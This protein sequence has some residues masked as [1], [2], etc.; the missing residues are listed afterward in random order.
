MIPIKDLITAPEEILDFIKDY[1]GKI[2]SFQFMI[3]A[4]RGKNDNLPIQ[5]MDLWIESYIDIIPELLEFRNHVRS[6]ME[7]LGIERHPDYVYGKDFNH[8]YH[9]NKA[10]IESLRALRDRLF[11]NVI[12]AVNHDQESIN[13]HIFNHKG[14][15]QYSTAGMNCVHFS[16]PKKPDIK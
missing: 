16:N 14:E 15:V 11:K 1:V 2:K 10:A 12:E 13:Q 3:E 5:N 8:Y 7:R 6:E 9:S 4:Y